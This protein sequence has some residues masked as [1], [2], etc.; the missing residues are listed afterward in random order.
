MTTR[1]DEQAPHD[2]SRAATAV[3][4]F[5]ERAYVRIVSTLLRLGLGAMWLT[6]GALKIGDPDGMV[7]SVRAFR[8]LPEALVEPVG[9]ALPF[10]E[11]ALGATL[12]VGLAVRAGAIVSTLLLAVY[13]AAIASAA[14]RGLRIDCGCFSSGGDLTAD[15]PTR[16]T[17][18]LVR[19]SLLVAASA[20]LAVFPRGYL[21]VDRL[22]DQSTTTDGESTDEFLDEPLE[23]E[24]LERDA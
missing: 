21:A 9:Y 11:V 20:L 10:V 13:V 7:R 22:L 2:H 4:A 24:P 1:F 14:A 19:D 16:Y 3:P 15:Q 6:A 8:I 23:D 12:V 17:S 18:E 5:G